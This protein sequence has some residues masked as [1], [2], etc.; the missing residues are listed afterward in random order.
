MQDFGTK[1][2]NSPPPGGQLS[3]A[4]FNNL[5][6]ENENAV[7]R[8]GL[9]LSGA[10]ATQLASSLFI[11]ATKAQAFQD[12][13]AAN[14]YVATPISG[15]SGVLLPV[16]YAALDG[17]LITLKA[18]NANTASSTL[19]IGQTTGTL[20]G[21]KLILTASG[22]VLNL[23][24]IRA[25]SY[26]QLRYDASLDSGSGAWVLIPWTANGG[27]LI[28]VQVFVANGTYTPTPGM[29]TCIIEAQGGGG[30]GGGAAFPSASFVSVGAPGTCGS[31]G[32]GQFTAAAIGVSKAVAIGAAGA[33]GGSG[34]GG[35]GGATSVGA[36]ISAPGGIGGGANAA[37]VPPIFNGNG[38][39][40]GAP[41]G[42]SLVSIQGAAGSSTFGVNALVGI[43]GTSGSTIFGP[44]SPGPSANSTP[45]AALNFGVGGAGCFLNN[46]G[47]GPLVGGSAKG[48]II[49]IWEYS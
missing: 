21:T 36:L 26:I 1:A 43:G 4:E 33:S 45:S 19:N 41:S 17:A 46:S 3:A 31:Y 11:H 24:A 34:A 12:S 32:K 20:L 42:A 10:S 37:A 6:T 48:G 8:A 29:A 15:L 27:Q 14:A 39:Y 7:L 30:C 40:A 16:N 47:G 44:S 22:T 18:S 23:G 28:N 13:G 38:A 9:A 5:A 25:G 35:N 2:D 49:I